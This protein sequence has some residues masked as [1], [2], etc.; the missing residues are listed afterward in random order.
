M[1]WARCT[2]TFAAAPKS[3]SV[4][5]F[6]N[7]SPILYIF[8][9]T[10]RCHCIYKERKT[11][12]P[13]CEAFGDYIAVGSYLVAQICS[14]IDR[15]FSNSTLRNHIFKYFK[16]WTNLQQPAFFTFLFFSFIFLSILKKSS[17]CRR[18]HCHWKSATEKWKN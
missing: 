14:S 13:I 5:L 3:G 12:T 11:Y 7:H 18:R 8:P 1:F 9:Y 2:T 6:S 4:F 17:C 10:Q 16:D 15:H